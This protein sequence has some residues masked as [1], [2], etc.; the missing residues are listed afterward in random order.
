MECNGAAVS[1]TTYS[2]LFAVIGEAY[3]AGNG[4]STFNLPDLRGEFIR[5][6]D[7]GKG[8]DSGRSIATSQG[9]QMFQHNHSVSASS[10]V[11]DPGHIHQVAYSNSDSGDGVI[12]EIT[13]ANL[14]TMINVEDGA[15]VTDATNV[16]SAGAVMKSIIDTKGDIIVGTA[17]NTYAKLAAGTNTYVLTADSSETAG[18]KWAEAR[19]GTIIALNNQTANRLTTI[20]ATTTELDGEA[21]LTFDGSTLAITGNQTVSTTLA[22]TGQIT[23]RGFECPAEVSDDWTIAAGNNAMF[24]GPM[25]VATGKTVTVPSG[26]TLTVV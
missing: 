15:D 1:R 23:G 24:P 14:R 7:N 17:D 12:E 3:G 25:T 16:T 6:F 21:N 26:R 9:S 22:A 18:L 10:S 20:G 8:T 19:S 11:T 4:S 13:P 5:G 2:A